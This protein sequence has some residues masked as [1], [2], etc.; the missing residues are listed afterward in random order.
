ML[1]PIHPTCRPDSYTK[2]EYLTA[3]NLLNNID[4]HSISWKI[5]VNVTEEAID[6]Y[7]SLELNCK[8]LLRRETQKTSRL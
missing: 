7:I 5:S 2:E 6:R 4:L 3:S 1:H 8:N